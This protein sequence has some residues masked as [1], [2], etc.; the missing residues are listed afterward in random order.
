MIL[1]RKS[2]AEENEFEACRKYNQTYE[3]RS[4]IPDNSLVIA[5]YSALPYYQE[6]EKELDLKNS[7]LVNSYAE[8][9]YI[10]DITQ[11]YSDL[12]AYT[13]ATWEN[14]IDLPSDTSFVIKG[15]TNSRKFNWKDLMFCKDSKEVPIKANRLLDD[16][17]IGQQG[18][19]VR[20]YV[21]LKTFKISLNG[22]PITN[23]WRF[24]CYKDQI[25]DYGYYWSISEDSDYYVDDEAFDL[26][27]KIMSLVVNKASFYVI[28]IAER[29]NGGWIMIELNDAQMSGLSCIDMDRFYQRLSGAIK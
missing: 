10:A 12:A 18:I 21:P 25:V 8:H 27:N 5:R 16:S 20:E 2:L 19:V 6:L 26:V 7:R 3:F 17:F 23:E 11:Y 1:F 28:D 4:E 13:P 22:L 9:S 29:A 14:W 15:K 24:F